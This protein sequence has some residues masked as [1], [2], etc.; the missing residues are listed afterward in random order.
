[1]AHPLDNQKLGARNGISRVSAM[2]EGY[3]NIIVSMDDEGRY[4][5]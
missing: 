1:M 5:H 3:K 2:N 4:F